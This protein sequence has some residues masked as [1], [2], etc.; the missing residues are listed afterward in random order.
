MLDAAKTEQELAGLLGAFRLELADHARAEAT[1]L[2]AMVERVRPPLI[3]G[4]I[5]QELE[6]EHRDQLAA[7]D[8]I[9]REQLGSAIWCEHV[10]QL[11]IRLLDHAW[12][13]HYFRASLLDHLSSSEREALATTYATERADNAVS[14]LSN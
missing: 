9:A 5:L 10:L 2:S 11:R 4:M 8:V 1:A 14:A 6:A 7:A 13:E 12:R 3:V